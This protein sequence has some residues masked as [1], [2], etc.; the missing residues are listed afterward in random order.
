[1]RASSS[2]TACSLSVIWRSSSPRRAFKRLSSRST[3]WPSGGPPATPPPRP[4]PRRP[5]RRRRREAGLP[6]PLPVE[7]VLVSA[8]IERGLAASDLDDLA[9][10]LVAEITVVGDE[11]ERAPGVRE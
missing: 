4:R 11:D 7:E 2:L 3:T 6:L 9:R 8:G 5:R 1:M 10:E